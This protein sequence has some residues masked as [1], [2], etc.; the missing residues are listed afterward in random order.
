MMIL[1]I[2]GG[3]GSG[4]T[5]VAQKIVEAVGE[6]RVLLLAQDAYYKDRGYL[7]FDKRAESNFDHPDAVDSELLAE[8][9]NRLKDGEPILQPVYDFA[10]HVRDTETRFLKPKPI[11][12]VEGILIFENE[13]LRSHFD[14]KVFV[15]ADA[16]IRFIRRLSRDLLS[17]GRTLDSVVQQYLR[18][19]RPMHL[20]FVEPSKRHADIILPEG[21]ES[22]AAMD[23][24]I[25]AVRDHLALRQ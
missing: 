21:G 9:L 25:R 15:D 16:D 5:T 19:V 7:P 18:S 12:I 2:C 24:L 11:V 6:E 22:P 14:L 4:K 10:R 20:E 13:K 17:R 3:T 8:H 23:F 1:G